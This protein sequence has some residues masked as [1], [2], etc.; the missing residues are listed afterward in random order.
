MFYVGT[1]DADTP[2]DIVQTMRRLGRQLARE[3]WTLRTN[4]ADGA[5]SAYEQGVDSVPGAKE[6]Y[7]PW[8]G[9]N[10]RREGQ[11]GASEAARELAAAAHPGW[12]R[13]TDSVKSLLATNCHLLL[14]R[15]LN[16]PARF[17]V[18]WTPDGAVFESERSTKTGS[19]A[20]L[21]VL[22][23]RHHIPRFNFNRG[24]SINALSR[25]I[26]EGIVP[27]MMGDDD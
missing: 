14:G 25:F 11:F 19:T 18:T 13:A 12:H 20:L 2:A 5:N 1:G 23:E 24:G 8:R 27:P 26:R 10:G 16:T 6:L 21:I 4:G 17:L 22:A 3:G 9:Y 15:D 7:L